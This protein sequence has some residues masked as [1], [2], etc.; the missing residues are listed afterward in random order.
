MRTRWPYALL[1]LLLAWG[2]V[3]ADP[4]DAQ[5]KAWTAHGW[6]GAS[7]IGN[8]GFFTFF[9]NGKIEL[10]PTVSPGPGTSTLRYNVVAVDGLY[11]PTT[12][13]GFRLVVRYKD[14]SPDAKIVVKLIETDIAFTGTETV[15]LTFDSSTK[16]DSPNYQSQQASACGAFNFQTKAYRVEV[17]FTQTPSATSAAKLGVHGF[18]LHRAN[19]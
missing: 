14:T 12:A 5:V 2:V 9:T 19:C 4:A 16:P 1:T 18:I 10:K 13:T 15:K 3:G 11:E 17:A 8:P 6:I 7:H